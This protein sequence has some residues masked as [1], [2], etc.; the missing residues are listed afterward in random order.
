LRHRELQTCQK[1]LRLLPQ[2]VKAP[3]RIRR[4]FFGHTHVA[5]AGREL[6][7]VKFYNPGAAIRHIA[8]EPVQFDLHEQ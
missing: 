6:N 8:F 7:G 2:L 4:V 1:L 5:V 3:G